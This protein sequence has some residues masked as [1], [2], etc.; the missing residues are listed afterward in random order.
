MA[1]PPAL[2]EIIDFFESLPTES[3]RREALISYAENA[4]M[5]A[6]RE[7]ESYAV[8]EVRKDEECLDRVGIHIADGARPRIRVSLG[9]KVQTLTRALTTI[10]CKGLDGSSR[11]TIAALDNE[12]VPRIVG[13]E[14]MRQRSRTVYY[15]LDR[16][17]E[18]CA[19]PS[20]R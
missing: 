11:E 20:S 9:E 17:R 15:V 19:R 14:L 1:Y 8:S 6:P 4:A 7:D 2:Q 16:L 13:A 5:H 3:E 12:F 10:L 18:V